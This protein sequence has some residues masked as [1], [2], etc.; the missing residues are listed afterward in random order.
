MEKQ[1]YWETFKWQIWHTELSQQSTMASS[2]V[3]TF[4]EVRSCIP[5]NFDQEKKKKKKIKDLETN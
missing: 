3:L 5:T 4:T 2:T 1:I